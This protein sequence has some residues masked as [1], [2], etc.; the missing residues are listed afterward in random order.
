MSQLKDVIKSNEYC[1]RTIPNY[2]K[3]LFVLRRLG[4]YNLYKKWFGIH[5]EDSWGDFLIGHGWQLPSALLNDSFC[6]GESW[7]TP[8]TNI[9]YISSRLWYEAE[10]ELCDVADEPLFDF[11]HIN[12]NRCI[13]NSKN[14]YKNTVNDIPKT[15]YMEG[16]NRAP[17]P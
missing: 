17:H 15:K 13:K 4:L 16:S 11:V 8:N 14:L 9:F 3:M 5:N 2:R 10:H 6:W 7:I 1:C 12:P